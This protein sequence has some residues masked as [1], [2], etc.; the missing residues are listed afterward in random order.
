MKTRLLIMIGIVAFVL[1]GIVSVITVMSFNA[2]ENVVYDGSLQ[3]LEAILSHCVDQKDLIDTAGLA[4]FNDTHRIDTVDC[5]WETIEQVSFGDPIFE[6]HRNELKQVLDW[7]N[8]TS[9]VKYGFYN[10]SN[11]THS[12]DT[13]TCEWKPH[14]PYPTGNNLCIPYVEKW[15][16]DEDWSN[17]T[18]YFDSDSC[19]WKVDPEYDFLNS[20]GCPQFCPKEKPEQSQIID[21]NC[22]TIEQ[23]K[24]TAPFFQT[25]S[26]LPDGYSYVCSRSGMPFESY[27]VYYNREFPA[28]WQI[29]ELVSHG[30]IFIYQIDERNF[31]GEKEFQTYG[32]AEQR[33]RET[34]DSVMEGN[35]SLNPQLITIN[36]MLAYAVDSCPDCGMQTANFTDRVIQKSTSTTTKIKFIDDNGVS[37]MLETTLPLHELIKVAESLQ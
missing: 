1:V 30:A 17:G 14:K 4:Y 16:A 12:I 9:G 28:N 18:H 20:K 2:N 3:Q 31:V 5:K 22:M 33:I 29:H 26:Y 7:C 34:Y 27:I 36:G 11:E 35:P 19:L 32:S 21:P 13:D 37:Y 8:D 15:V 25:P 23:S 10:Y 24:Q 6:I